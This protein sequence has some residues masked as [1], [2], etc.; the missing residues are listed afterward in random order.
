MR[1]RKEESFLKGEINGTE[2]KMR[3]N[4][5]SDPKNVPGPDGKRS[6]DGSGK[7]SLGKTVDQTGYLTEGK[8]SFQS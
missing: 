3:Q 1:S 5:D 2:M 4:E 6:S 7:A 8:I